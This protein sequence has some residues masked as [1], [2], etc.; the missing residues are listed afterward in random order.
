MFLPT[1]RNLLTMGLC[2]AIIWA[3]VPNA[4]AQRFDRGTKIT[5]DQPFDIPG[6]VAL[7][8]GTYMFRLMDVPGIRT[9]V[10][11]L[12]ADQTKSY[13]IALAIP[14]YRLKAPE[15]TDIT[16]YE[17]EPGMPRPVR[18]WFYPQY[19]YG[20]EFVY[21]KKRAAEIARFSGEH[22][23]ATPWEPEY[24]PEAEELENEPLIAVEP[25]GEEV[26]VAA[27]HPETEAPPVTE[28]A[29]SEPVLTAEAQPPELP[30][31]ATPVPFIALSGLAA[32]GAAGVLRMFR[33]RNG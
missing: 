9:V 23:I 31:T 26:E 15:K 1:F 19:N 7:P 18:A 21:P 5:I 8:P 16:F 25:T 22:V 11:V 14:D 29:P 6:V 20:V 4:E 10:Q 33:K 28:A 2:L 27:V 32:A 3:F 17:A 13:G 24:V 30:R 12:N